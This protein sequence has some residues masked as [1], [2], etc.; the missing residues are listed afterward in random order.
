VVDELERSYLLSSLLD[1]L[2]KLGIYI[3]LVVVCNPMM[4]AF[5]PYPVHTSC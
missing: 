1:S 2:S 4:P 5:M 3:M